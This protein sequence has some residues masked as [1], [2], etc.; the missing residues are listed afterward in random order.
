MVLFNL[1]WK[2][3]LS[4]DTRMQ[5]LST[6]YVPPAHKFALATP[7]EKK[8]HFLTYPRIR[9]SVKVLRKVHRCSDMS[10]QRID[11]Y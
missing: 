7:T 4:Y 8:N 11:I 6:G 2:Q 1:A 3:N 10:R 9:F 5:Q